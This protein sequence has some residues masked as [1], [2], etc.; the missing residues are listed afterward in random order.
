MLKVR[1]TPCTTF[2]CVWIIAPGHEVAA[3]VTPTTLSQGILGRLETVA[4]MV[5]PLGSIVGVESSRA[6][7]RSTV[8]VRLVV[9][10]QRIHQPGI[11][12]RTRR[13]E[14]RPC[15]DRGLFVVGLAI[16]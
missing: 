8:C 1:S 5:G 9:A 2:L 12:R 10:A 7:P 6:V 11:G 13:R 3:E 14:E 15:F 4:G 16:V